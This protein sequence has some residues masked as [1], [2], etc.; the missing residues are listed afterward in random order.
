M[1]FAG[2]AMHE[3][4]S[5]DHAPAKCGADGLMPQADTEDGDFTS[6]ALDERDADAGFVRRAG[7][8]RNKN[9]IGAEFLDFGDRRL[10][11]EALGIRRT[12]CPDRAADRNSGSA[13]LFLWRV[14]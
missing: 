6:E 7:A 8:W 13:A 5:A 9:A 4:R 14:P 11:A 12:I 3:L 1:N 2:L 10:R